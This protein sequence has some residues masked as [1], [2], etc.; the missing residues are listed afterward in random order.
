MK[1]GKKQFKPHVTFS[2]KI[3]SHLF[4]IGIFPTLIFSCTHKHGSTER[5][6]RAAHFFT[7]KD[8]RCRKRC[9]LFK[10]RLFV[11][12]QRVRNSLMTLKRSANIFYTA[13]FMFETD[14]CLILECLTSL[15]NHFKFGWKHNRN[16]MRQLYRTKGNQLNQ[17]KT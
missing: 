4:G 14:V 9:E 12:C 2:R 10:M 15:M 7:E 6:Q 3:R 1:L 8:L 5:N 13:F 16:P 11:C 17:K